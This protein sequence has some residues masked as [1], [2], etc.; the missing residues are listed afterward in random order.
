M[1]Y[2]IHALSWREINS[3]HRLMT[4][5]VLALGVLNF[6]FGEIVP[7]GNG[8]GWDGL[9]YANITRNLGPMVTEG[10]LSNYYAHRILPSAVVRSLLLL[11]GAS[12]SDINI[13]RGFECYNLVLLVG[14]SWVWRRIANSFSISLGGRWLGFCGLFL[15]F[16][17]SKQTFYY[18]VL[19]D[20]TALFV[21]L[22]ALLFYVERRPVALLVTTIVGAFAWQVVSICGALLLMFP[23]AELPPE[24]IAPAKATY[25]I[26]SAKL[27]RLIKFGWVVLLV[28]SIAGVA[29]CFRL[30]RVLDIAR[31]ERVIAKHGVL[32]LFDV[33]ANR[34][35]CLLTG[36]PSLAGATIALAMLA[37]SV[38]FFQV[39]VANLRKTR[40]IQVV[41]V[42]AA[43]LIPWSIVRAISNPV[44]S[45]ISG[46]VAVLHT[47][48]LPQNGKILLPLVT[49]AAFWGPVVLLLLLNWKSFCSEARQLGPG[50][51][52]VV[53]LNLP[54]GLPTEPRFVTFGWPFFV[55]GA[56][57]AMEGRTRSATFK[58]AFAALTILYSQFWMKINLVPWPG[59]DNEYLFEFP[60]Q[61]Y[62]M[63]LGMWM[64][65]WS[66]SLQLCA[67]ALSALWLRSTMLR[68]CSASGAGIS[69]ALSKLSDPD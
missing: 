6:F 65:W 62:L 10:Q 46:F 35:G 63:H 11:S 17:G 18:P 53:G 44:V 28:L 16:M 32:W 45:N 20:T 24:V 7:A 4:A 12:F 26:N 66:Y 31:L 34:L 27:S 55:L 50:F 25:S 68:N 42:L 30:E 22:L 39:V 67:I 36:L 1:K 51:M 56:V 49:L 58:Y 48:L 54:L 59:G 52:A 23:R 19:T 37:G 40:L 41:M 13:I 14:A 69:P 61:L 33:L 8:L 57:L 5:I 43:L 21:G 64:N 29:G 3:S 38:S 60:K 2:I 9:T 47:L 15:S